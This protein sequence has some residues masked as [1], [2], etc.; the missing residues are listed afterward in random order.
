[1]LLIARLDRDALSAAVDAGGLVPAGERDLQLRPRSGRRQWS[2][3]AYFRGWNG[4]Q[5]QLRHVLPATRFII[6]VLSVIGNRAGLL[7]G[8]LRL[9]AA[10]VR[11][12]RASGSR[13]ML[14]TLML[15]YQV[16]LIPQYVLFLKLGWVEH[17]PA[18]GRA[19]IP[20]GRR[21]L[22]LP[23]GAVLPRHPAELDEAAMMD[24]CS[25]LAHLLED[26]AAALAAGAGDGRDLHLHLDLGR[27]L[28]PAD[29]PQRH[30]APTP[31]M[32]GLRTFADSTG[33]S[34]WGGLFA[35]SSLTLVPV[36]LF[37]LFFQRLLIEGIA[38]TG[39]KR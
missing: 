21:L 22:H 32:L 29:L 8:R 18:A 25:P 13:M 20:R 26:H 1:M 31:C 35:M 27:F 6:S 24:G 7:A 33:E 3:D 15:P 37:F 36:F 5:R 9:R 23:D 34:D 17:L 38:T 11:G 12:P 2:I 14:G 4:L 39:M 19:E 10:E 16:T 30:A 28:R